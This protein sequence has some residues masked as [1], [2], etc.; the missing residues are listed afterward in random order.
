MADRP[1]KPEG[2]ASW[3]VAPGPKPE[4]WD[5]IRE[6]GRRYC[7]ANTGEHQGED[8]R[9]GAG[10][11]AWEAHGEQY[12]VGHG[13]GVLEG[14]REGDREDGAGECAGQ[15]RREAAQDDHGKGPVAGTREGAGEACCADHGSE[16]I[17]LVSS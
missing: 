17:K 14:G 16:M 6:V 10:K 5:E 12:S 9:E 1:R 15:E 3:H 11:G 13:E 4:L 2:G 8:F 7:V